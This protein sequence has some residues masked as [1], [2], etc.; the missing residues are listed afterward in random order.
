MKTLFLLSALA[1]SLPAAIIITG[2]VTGSG[3]GTIS[4]GTVTNPSPGNN[5]DP[6]QS[7]NLFT[8]VESFTSTGTLYASFSGGGTSGSTEYFVTK[9]ITNN[10]TDTWTSFAIGVGCSGFTRC[11]FGYDP[12]LMD[13]DLSPTIDRS[14]TSLSTTPIS[15]TFSNINL[16]PTQS[17]IITFSMDTCTNCGFG[18]SMFE[19]PGTGPVVPE[20][21]TYALTGSA[22]LGLGY[23]ARRRR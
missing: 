23:A 21:A 19:L 6:G 17:M 1:A 22:M 12:L 16:A 2:P 7:P 5:N 4:V 9:T 14:G 18:W 11:T 15:L 13:Y 8:L 10:T 20:P 3:A